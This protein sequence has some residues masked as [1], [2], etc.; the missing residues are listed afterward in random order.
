MLARIQLAIFAAVIGLLAASPSC[1][2]PSVKQGTPPR[3]TQLQLTPLPSAMAEAKRMDRDEISDEQPSGFYARRGANVTLTVTRLRTDHKLAVRVG[4]PSMWEGNNRQ[5][6]IPLSNGRNV[7]RANNLGPLMLIYTHDGNRPDTVDIDVSGASPM[8]LLVDNQTSAAAWERQLSQ[9]SNAPFVSLVSNRSMITMSMRTYRANPI[10]EPSRAFATIN[11]VINWEDE[12]AGFDNS[13]PVH[14]PTPL[15]IHYI[16]DI[17]TSAGEA[18]NFDMHETKGMIGMVST[19]TRDLT[20]PVELSKKWGI[21]HETG[22]THQQKSWTWGDLTEINVNI[23]SLYVQSKFGQRSRL[24]DTSETSKTTLQLAREGLAKGAPDY[25]AVSDDD[26]SYFIKLVMFHQLKEAYGWRIFINLHKAVRENPL[27][28][29]ASDSDRIDLF[30][31]QTCRLT[32]N[33]LLGFFAKWGLVPSDEAAEAIQAANY[34]SPRR[35][36]ASIF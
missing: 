29:S 7:I 34:P 10:R 24:Y 3:S 28:A 31:T 19:N 6:I 13:L 35:D 23:F 20:D 30:V 21:W 5:Q 14:R 26:N 2:A 12:V 32:G 17:Y 11:Q 9:F 8:P 22:H 16:E 18:D 4:F 33:N 25:N 27:P 15:R 36:P 1:G